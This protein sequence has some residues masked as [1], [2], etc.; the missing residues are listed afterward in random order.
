MDIN[1]W[2]FSSAAARLCRGGTATPAPEPGCSPT[3]GAGG[4]SSRSH[5]SLEHHE[6]HPPPSPPPPAAPRLLAVPREKGAGEAQAPL[7]RLGITPRPQHGL[8]PVPEG[9]LCSLKAQRPCKPHP[10]H[11][12]SLTK[13]DVQPRLVRLIW[14]QAWTGWRSLERQDSEAAAQP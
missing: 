10:G 7:S 5:H 14:N 2:H 12:S 9:K 3:G 6:K 1:S 13:Q 4:E 8:A 11:R